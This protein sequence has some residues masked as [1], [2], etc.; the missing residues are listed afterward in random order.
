MPLGIEE[1][2]HDAA[3]LHRFIDS[4][5]SGCV[6]TEDYPSYAK[7]S[8][9]LFEY[10]YS[11]AQATK[12]HLAQFLA[13]LDPTLA[14]TD[15]E[16]FYSRTQVIRTLRTS[17]FELHQLV[18]PAL[19]ADTLHVPYSLIDAL[20]A[21]LQKIQGFENVQFAVLHT[22]E[23]NYF[24][25]SA[26]YVQTVAQDIGAIVTKAQAFPTDLGIIALPYSQASAIF[27]NVALAHEMGHFAFQ[28]RNES[29]R[30]SP[31]VI[32]TVQAKTARTLTSLELVW[33]KDRVLRWCEE[34]YCDL[35]ALWLIGPSFSFSYIELFAFSRVTPKFS[36][37]TTALP[38]VAALATFRD[39]HPAA[40]FRLGEHVRFL[41]SAGLDWW[42]KIKTSSSH[43]IRLLAEA[44]A[45]PENS[46]TYASQQRDDLK[47]ISLAAFFVV[48]PLISNSLR[49]T[50]GT[51]PS[52]SKSFED[53][54][55]SIIEYLSY[56]IV[57]SR[58]VSGDEVQTPSSVALINSA[59]L[60]Y[61][62]DLDNLIG[63]IQG[64]NVDCLE[65]RAL[66]SERVEMWTSKAL[67]DVSA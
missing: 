24:Q 2:R 20:T 18:K 14:N 40:A 49:S 4:I 62:D 54:R 8:K 22:T 9:K 10:I 16:D 55:A 58:L 43:Y 25:I 44:E 30:L 28:I 32:S 52:E 45:L 59:H 64:A 21:R 56:G 23:L 65:C 57:P 1:V 38:P 13:D 37:G 41:R 19:D 42:E 33:C 15:P 35:F 51:V 36:P 39:S 17:W 34:I 66:W 53:S 7:A 46:F 50:F 67:E 60:F 6:R 63:R 31:A 26:S 11:L 3:A 29:V 61:L 27:L 48:V 5:A 47:A 12:A